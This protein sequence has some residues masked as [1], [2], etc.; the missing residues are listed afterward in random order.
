MHKILTEQFQCLPPVN[1]REVLRYAGIKAEIAQPLNALL[2]ECLQEAEGA[3]C[4]KACY[5]QMSLSDFFSSVVSATKSHSIKTALLGCEEVIVFT[6]TVGLE[7]DR[8]IRRY[9]RISPTK[10]LLFQSLGTE[11]IEAVCDLF[12]EKLML[13]FNKKNV[14]LKPRFSAGYG[15]FSIEAQRE[16]FAL[17]DVSKHIG[18]SLTES[19]M[20]I[21]TK[22]VS[23]L[24]GIRR[25]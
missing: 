5:L 4:A 3:F 9:L 7:I 18:V 6:A 19:L 24:V 14:E 23:A 21:P 8:L 17:L 10:A 11:R 15:D 1:K 13:G 20:M 25:K 12:C 22:S 16:F 2:D